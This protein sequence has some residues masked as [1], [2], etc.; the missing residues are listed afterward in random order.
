MLRERFLAAGVKRGMPRGH[1]RWVKGS[2]QNLSPL[3]KPKG[4]TLANAAALMRQRSAEVRL[5]L[6]GMMK[7]KGVPGTAVHGSTLQDQIR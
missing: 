7:M 6:P 4:H 3:L 2:P 5:K 1:T